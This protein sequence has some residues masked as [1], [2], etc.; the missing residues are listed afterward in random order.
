MGEE[1]RGQAEIR[2]FGP[3]LLVIS[4]TDSVHD[5]IR[6]LLATLRKMRDAEPPAKSAATSGPSSDDVV[7][8]SY[9][10]Q[11]NPTNDLAAMRAQV[12]ALITESLPNETWN[13]RLANGEGV[14]LT[15]FSD[16]IVV[17]QRAD[18]QDK[19]A[20]ILADSGVAAPANNAGTAVP[21]GQPSFGA[22]PGA[23]PGRGWRRRWILR[24]CAFRRPGRRGWNW[25][26][27]GRPA[28]RT[29]WS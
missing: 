28:G 17:R 27:S 9:M 13:G 15:V 18:V 16:R 12:R 23:M 19:V 21:G 29:L 2:A 20:K 1:R 11:L 3:G 22:G 8:R 10:L 4:Q 6:G 5:Q 7:T 24:P 25:S 14:T 26:R